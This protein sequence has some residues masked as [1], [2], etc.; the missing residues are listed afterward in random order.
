M[1]ERIGRVGAL[2]LFG[3]L[4][5]AA[6][7]GYWQ[8]FQVV[9]A[10]QATRDPRLY[11]LEARVQRGDIVDRRGKALATTESTTRGFVRRYP[12]AAAAPVVGYPSSRYGRGGLEERFDDRLSGQRS[13][14]ILGRLQDE[15]FHRP[16]VGSQIRST[17]DL[18]IQQVAT[19]AMGDAAG[20]IVALDPID[21][22]VLALVSA[23]T[24]DPGAIDGSI[25]R[26]RND[27]SRPLFNRATQGLYPPGSTFKVVT[28]A[29]V[30]ENKVVDLKREFRCTRPIQ[31]DGLAVDCRNHAHLAVVDFYEAFAWSC[32]RTFALAGLGL[33]YPGQVDL[34]DNPA[35][36]YPW[37][38]RGIG[39][40]ADRLREMA[41][42]FGLERTVPFDLPVEPSRLAD[43]GQE[44]FPS[45]LGQTAFGQ[46]Q[47]ALTP[48][49][50][51][52]IIG[53]VANGG[54]MPQPHLGLEALGPGGA[55]ND[56][57]PV[58]APQSRVIS[59]E[60]A[61][62][63]N[64]MLE[65]SVDHAYAQKAKIAGVKVAGKTGT[66]EVGDGKT[67][68]SW[69]IGYAPSDKPR[70]AVAVVLENRGSGAEAATIA[71]QRVLQTALAVYRPAN[72]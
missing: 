32:N 72:R 1:D 26:L 48:L 55:R 38:D 64:H 52:L 33:G 37:A 50:M 20:A 60:T 41:G 69:F 59:A 3:F 25:D 9:P 36:P 5:V 4:L 67:P 2:L 61:A 71:A 21:G 24:F 16:A 63:L 56:L 6:A 43:P 19:S 14:G 30:V 34:S 12:A 51:A 49:Q 29:A 13:T 39:P 17:L 22:D 28:A 46:G 53:T 62:E 35:R 47:L 45:L 15:L 66:A 40:S 68:H 11:E 54:L 57:R 10:E 23:P 70:V 18:E 42:K 31:I 65:M 58:P 27:L 44:M 8:V 7:L